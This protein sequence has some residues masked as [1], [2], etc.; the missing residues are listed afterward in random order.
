M[1]EGAHQ[2]PPDDTCNLLFQAGMLLVLLGAAAWP[3]ISFFLHI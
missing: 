3:I 1:G 2:P